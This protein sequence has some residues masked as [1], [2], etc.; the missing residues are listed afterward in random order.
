MMS[1]ILI[2]FIILFSDKKFVVNNLKDGITFDRFEYNKKLQEIIFTIVYD[3]F[4]S[5]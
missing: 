5:V 4:A 3:R 1:F 2:I